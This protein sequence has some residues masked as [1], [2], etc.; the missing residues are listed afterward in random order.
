MEKHVLE[1]LLKEAGQF[2]I[3]G[4]QDRVITGIAIDSRKVEKGFL[5]GAFKGAKTDGHEYIERA[6][7]NGATA[8]LC[9]NWPPD[10]EADVTLIKVGDS[11][12]V[13]GKI[14][15]A[16]YGNPS[17]KL[18]CIGV[19]G[20]N[21]KTTVTTLL[22]NLF[23][24]L[25]YKVGLISTIE[26]L[27]NEEKWDASLTT[28]DV[29]SLH[30]MLS[31]M[32][33]NNCSHVFMEVSSH[34]L[35]Q[36]RISGVHFDGGV[37][38]NITHDH[39]DY[40]GSFSNYIKAKQSFFTGLS[41]SAFA[42]T[43]MDDKNGEV[44]LQQT[45]ARSYK[46]SLRRLTDYKGKVLSVEAMG[47]YLDINGYK[48]MT[49]LTGRFNAANLT[50]VFAVASLM[51]VADDQFIIEKLSGLTGA[52][53]RMEVVSV[54]PRVIVDY[55]H[56]PD[57]LA[58]VLDTLLQSKASGQLIVIVG[59][60]GNRDHSKRPLMG[61]IACEKSDQAIFTADN[62]RNERVMDIISDM[63]H[64]LNA[65]Q[66]AGLLEI[67]D[68]TTAIKTALKLAHE[69]DT[70]LIAGKGHEQYQE[71]NGERHFFSDQQIVKDILS[72]DI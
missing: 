71:I 63:K 38:T 29:V 32:V 22:Y 61:V 11:R 68:R 70:V 52:M 51:Q 13:I 5:F 4:K 57:A 44:M 12:K 58:N 30:H 56:T 15:S 27:V 40:H 53:G 10:K 69:N 65:A 66:L 23:K 33:N 9:E 59:C 35:D 7:E 50:A 28:P 36:Q 60:G 19:T 1:D 47:M 16:F 48:F 17:S 67:P 26:I 54:K 34:A 8:I 2:E 62:P 55:A 49:R 31:K 6:I 72:E 25:G 3:R 41:K 21:G 39:L 45:R 14:S 43:N 37:F 20:T 18:K 24:E 64:S 42:L 46:Y